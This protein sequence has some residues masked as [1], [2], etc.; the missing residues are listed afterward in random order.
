M[1]SF[2]RRCYEACILVIL[3]T[4]LPLL[5]S[6]QN[7]KRVS[8]SKKTGVL[9]RDPGNISR[10]DLFYG[11]GSPS[12]APVPPFKYLEE[13][14]DGES[15]K[16]KIRDAKGVEWSVKMGPEAQSETVVSRLMWAMGYFAEEAYYFDRVSVNGLPKLSRGRDYVSGNI[17]KGVR[18]EPRREHIDRGDTWKWLENPH[19]GTRELSG[20][21]TIMVLMANY[22]TSTVNNRILHVKDAAA[23]RTENR[24][25][26]TDVGATLGKIGGMGRKRS[27]NNLRDY[28]N[29]KFI[30]KVEN[31]Y[32]EFDYNTTPS[33][34]G[35]FTFVFA[36]RYWRSQAN[37]EKAMKRVPIA[38]AQWIGSMLS[39]LSNEQL[40]A[41]FRAA[42]YDPTTADGFISTI[43][44]RIDQLNS[45]SLT[46]A[47]S[48]RRPGRR[49]ER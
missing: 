30:K 29:N 2:Q 4:L 46:A 44:G 26:V 32:V 16:F 39:R 36:P 13:D 25:V 40:H 21:K 11:P 10:L 35:Y 6:G 19:V 37:K 12:L 34:L 14:K 5:A 9:W 15:P 1:S 43:K 41:A 49:T 48:V 28:R 20:L 8:N 31:G 47:R 23:D 17:V 7:T 42:N 45:L 27:K 3:L 22:D 33:K 38:H 24:Y 18:F